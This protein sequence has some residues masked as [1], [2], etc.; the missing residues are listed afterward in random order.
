MHRQGSK[1]A[2]TLPALAFAVNG[3]T[4]YS[5]LYAYATTRVDVDKGCAICIAYDNIA[6]VDL[7]MWKKT[8]S[9]M[10]KDSICW[11]KCPY[12]NLCLI[13]LD[14]RAI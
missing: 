7:M 3:C 1:T 12:V 2:T 8:L 5:I 13:F 6:I 14:E 10:S 9:G 11:Q 4:I